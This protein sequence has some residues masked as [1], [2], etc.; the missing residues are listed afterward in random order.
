M[1]TATAPL[2]TRRSARS[3]LTSCASAYATCITATNRTGLCPLVRAH[4]LPRCASPGTQQAL[5]SRHFVLAGE[6]A[7]G[8]GLT[9]RQALAALLF[10]Y[11]KVLCTD[12]PASGDR[13][14][15]V[16]AAF[17][18]G[19][20]PRMKRFASSVFW[21]ASIASVRPVSYER[22]ADRGGSAT[23]VKDLDFRSRHG[24][25]EGK[26]SA[27][28]PDVTRELRYPAARAAVAYGHGG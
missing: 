15:L 21:K 13:K 10:F 16:V 2:A 3:V 6:R 9:H 23:V 27:I 12:L 5:K 24:S 17:A 7:Q 8:F 22:H 28:G 19:A 26:G 25:S 4:P 20:G 1:K 11:G 14:I 18:G